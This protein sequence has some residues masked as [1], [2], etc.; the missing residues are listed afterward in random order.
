MSYYLSLAHPSHCSARS[1]P[2]FLLLTSNNHSNGGGASSGYHNSSY[3]YDSN[4]NGGRGGRGGGGGDGRGRGRDG[5]GRG[6]GRVLAQPLRSNDSN[7]TLGSSAKNDSTQPQQSNIYD[8]NANIVIGIDDTVPPGG[9]IVPDLDIT[10]HIRGND[11]RNNDKN[12]KS[13]K[14]NMNKITADCGRGSEK[15][16]KISKSALN[17]NDPYDL[18]LTERE[19]SYVTADNK[20]LLFEVKNII[21]IFVLFFSS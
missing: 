9:M 14:Y 13:E 6:G 4:K 3:Y 7:I 19:L 16:E 15:S 2:L 5:R 18:G 17:P 10:A 20:L 12:I 11:S 21:V 1:F 8:V